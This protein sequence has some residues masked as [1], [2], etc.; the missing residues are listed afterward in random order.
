VRASVGFGYFSERNNDE[1][2]PLNENGSVIPIVIGNTFFIFSNLGL[3]LL[4]EF[5]YLQKS[6][7][8]NI[9]F[10]IG[11]IYFTK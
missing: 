6:S 2:N 8:D 9:R 7:E 11:F 5:D 1:F 10:K 4:G 3:N